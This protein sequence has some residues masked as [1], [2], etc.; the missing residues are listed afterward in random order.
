MHRG[1]RRAFA[2][3]DGTQRTK[4]DHEADAAGITRREH[5]LPDSRRALEE[6]HGLDDGGA[7]PVPLGAYLAWLHGTAEHEQNR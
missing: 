4:G 3:R 2:L 7:G 1:H 6:R 5:L